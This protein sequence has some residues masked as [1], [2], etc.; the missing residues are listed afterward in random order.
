MVALGANVSL[1]TTDLQ[2]GNT[3]A[4]LFANS[5][6]VKV[7]NSSGTANLEPTKLTVG[8]SIVNSTVIVV[9][10]NVAVNSSALFIGD[11]SA[12]TIANSSVVKTG[13]LTVTGAISAN[14]GVGTNTQVLTSDGTKTYWGSA[15]A[16]ATDAQVRAA[17]A[18]DLA[19]RAAALG[20]AAADVALTDAA[21]IAV[22]WAS[23]IN[24]TV[25][26]TTSRILGNPTNGIPGTWRTILFTQSATG[27]DVITFG[28]QYVAPY[29]TKPIIA[30]GNAA[31]TR[32]SIYC[33]TASIFEVYG[34]GI[35]LA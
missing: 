19:I 2:I 12:N 25:T 4:N 34:M 15:T 8:I 24:F 1:D 14:G 22:D 3:T 32:L 31:K 30:T 6:L 29:G 10:A 33:R 23:G 11:G 17:S 28:N 35:G 9:G 26:T 18:G 21:T 16:F 27:T 13:Q 7:A 5:I 20:T